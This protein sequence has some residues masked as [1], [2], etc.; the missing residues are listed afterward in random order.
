VGVV[1]LLF[2][3]GMELPL[4]H[5]TELR[6]TLL[7]GGSLQMALT[8]ASG[9]AAAIA[10]GLGWRAGILL[11]LLLAMSSTA[12]ATK[13]LTD[14]GELGS[15]V[16]RFCLAI[17]VAQDLAV[18][19]VILLLPLLA[20]DGEHAGDLAA[21]TATAF[22]GLVLAVLAAKVLAPRLLDLVCRTR[23]REAFVL[24]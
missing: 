16:A 13:L 22:V 9:A 2:S 14:R 8:V 7:I 6:R 5:L 15:P 23:S 20:G 21:H 24:A 12:L 18:V 11:G 4:R 10:F 1:I 19:P 3:V 17:L